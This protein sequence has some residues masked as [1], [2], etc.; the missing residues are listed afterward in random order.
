MGPSA[1]WEQLFVHEWLPLLN[2]EHLLP[3]PGTFSFLTE[4]HQFPSCLKAVAC[5]QSY[6][7]LVAVFEMTSTCSSTGGD[8]C[9]P[10]NHGLFWE[11]MNE[12]ELICLPRQHF[13]LNANSQCIQIVHSSVINKNSNKFSQGTDFICVSGLSFQAVSPYRGSNAM[14]ANGTFT[15]YIMGQC[16]LLL[17]LLQ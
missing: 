13:F 1:S 2:E 16:S 10:A 12:R 4:C 15:L 8:C 6:R 5:S 7:F 14:S 3:P 9:V 17:R 11:R